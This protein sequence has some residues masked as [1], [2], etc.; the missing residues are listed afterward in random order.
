M[1]LVLAMMATLALTACVS[2]NHYQGARSAAPQVTAPDPFVRASRPTAP[3]FS[4]H[5]DDSKPGQE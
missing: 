5:A 2:G 3:V 1:K 4:A